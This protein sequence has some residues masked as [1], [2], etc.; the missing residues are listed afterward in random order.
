[1]SPRAQLVTVKQMS[2]EKYPVSWGSA[3]SP[4]NGN[5]NPNPQGQI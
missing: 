1:V 2:C 4:S 5:P 3:L